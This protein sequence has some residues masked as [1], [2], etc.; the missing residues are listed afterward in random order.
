MIEKVQIEVTTNCNLRCEY[1]LKPEKAIEI[2]EE[3]VEKLR[4]VAKRFIFYGFGEPMLNKNLAKF[5]E[6]LDGESVLSTNAMVEENFYEIAQLFD[7]V[8][9][10]ID[11][12]DFR[13]GLVLEKAMEKIEKLESPFAQFV[14]LEENFPQFL[15]LANSLAEKGIKV[16]ATNAIAPS[17]RIYEKTLYFEGSRI[18]LEHVH[19]TEGEIV[20]MI[21]RFFYIDPGR[22]AIAKKSPNFQAIIEA[23]KRILKAQKIDERIKEIKSS[24]KEVFIAPEFFGE[25]E[26]RE[27]PYKN[28]IFVRADGKV[29]VCMELAYEHNEFVNRRLK[30]VEAFVIGDLLE[31]DIDE[32]LENL[33]EFEARRREVDFPWCGDCAHVFGCWFLENGM[34]CYGNKP[35]CSECLY[36]VS[37]AKC[38]V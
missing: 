12:A 7:V 18:N 34:D 5:V 11:T 15:A 19:L 31:Q 26:K 9:V 25:S 16:L 17:S 23:R 4:G 2:E 38:L 10:S 28:A 8:G 35:S 37:I 13:K 36:S 6:L 1:C 20:E 24:L 21:K 14:I 32:I 27:C 22:K 3:I 33:R 30:K 29:S